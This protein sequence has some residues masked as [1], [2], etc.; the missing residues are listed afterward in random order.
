MK[1][2]QWTGNQQPT[3]QPTVVKGDNS[4]KN[5]AIQTLIM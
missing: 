2:V 4:Q 1:N 3:K 5:I